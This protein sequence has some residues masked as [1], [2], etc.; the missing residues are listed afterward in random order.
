MTTIKVINV[1][2]DFH[3][4]LIGRFQTDSD[5]NGAK[6]RDEYLVPALKHFDK[7]QVNFTGVEGYGSSFLDEAFG[8]LI[9]T[10]KLTKEYVLERLQLVADE[11]ASLV[12][13][14]MEY[15]ERA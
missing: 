7:V 6:F 1:A 13:E 9:H 5:F 11:D 10:S 15:I 8:G 3:D 14:I 4:E 2:K 12:E